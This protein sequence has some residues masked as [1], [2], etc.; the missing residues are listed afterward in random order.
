MGLIFFVVVFGALV[1]ISVGAFVTFFL[2]V[3]EL[4]AL[5]PQVER[6]SLLL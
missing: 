1:G 4:F 2:Y 6:S 5:W 3:L